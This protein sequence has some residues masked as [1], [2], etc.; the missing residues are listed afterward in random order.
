MLDVLIRVAGVGV[1]FPDDSPVI[2]DSSHNHDPN[3]S[4]PAILCGR[5][6]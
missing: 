6:Q 3:E 1:I 4:I 2:V 5:V